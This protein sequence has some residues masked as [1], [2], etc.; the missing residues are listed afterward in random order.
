M[1]KKVVIYLIKYIFQTILIYI[2][3]K[4]F[5]SSK[6]ELNK[7]IFYLLGIQLTFDIL[8]NNKELFTLTNIISS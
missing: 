1:D 3:I 4:N 8:S 5:C 7:I 6:E 2:I